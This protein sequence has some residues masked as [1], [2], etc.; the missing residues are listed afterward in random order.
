MERQQGCCIYLT[1]VPF[2]CMLYIHILYVFTICATWMQN[3]KENINFTCNFA[4]E[5]ALLWKKMRSQKFTTPPFGILADLPVSSLH[6]S[7]S[8]L[9]M[10]V[11]VLSTIVFVQCCDCWH[12]CMSCPFST[13][14]KHTKKHPK[15]MHPAA[16]FRAPST[17]LPP[18][19]AVEL[20]AAFPARPG[21]I[22][23]CSNQTA[24]KKLASK[25]KI[26]KQD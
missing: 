20:F 7:F 24:G 22:S 11:V 21:G 12:Q 14:K 2:N 3:L 4:T 9:P 13:L 15:T 8:E 25:G 23:G 17:V 19:L 1:P 16:V 5:L 26:A 10:I 18:R 6:T